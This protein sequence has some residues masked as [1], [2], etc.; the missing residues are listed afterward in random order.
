[1]DKYIHRE[2][3]ALFRKRLAE[4]PDDAT[5]QVLLKLLAEEEAKDPPSWLKS[6]S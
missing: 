5:R 2:N 1:M 3:L 4:A 6:K